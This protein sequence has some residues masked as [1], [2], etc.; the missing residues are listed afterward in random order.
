MY[1]TTPGAFLGPVARPAPRPAGPVGIVV[2]TLDELAAYLE[3]GAVGPYVIVRTVDDVPPVLGGLAI[4]SPAVLT[5]ELMTALTRA[6]GV[7]A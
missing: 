6:T 5:P 7:T 4:L 3:L 1:P 2:D